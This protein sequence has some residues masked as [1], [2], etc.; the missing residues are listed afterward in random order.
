MNYYIS[1][2]H[3]GHSNCLHFDNRPFKDCVEQEA[4]MIKRW[5]AVVKSD[6]TVYILGDFCWVKNDWVRILKQL[7]G[8]KI[9]IKGNHDNKLG[10]DIK[11][12]FEAIY[13]YLEIVDNNRPVTLSHYPI[14]CFKGQY[15]G[16]Y[17]LYGHVHSSFQWNMMEHDR[18]LTEQLYCKPCEMYNVGCMMPYMNYAPKTLDDI[19][20]GYKE[21]CHNFRKDFEEYAETE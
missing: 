17:M 7:N 19:I 4:E 12:Q 8:R 15:F 13:D 6:D 3:F 20:A 5:N 2:T 16:A 18:Y 14:P 9:L 1:D 10:D 21:Y 11:K